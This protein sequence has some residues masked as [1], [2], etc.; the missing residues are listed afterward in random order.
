MLTWFVTTLQKNAELAVFIALAAGYYIGPKKIAGFGLGNGTATLLAGVVVGQLRI[1]ISPPLKA[2]AFVLFLFA[3]GYKVGPQFFAGLKREGLRQVM[4]GLFYAVLGL[5]ASAGFAHAVHFNV[6]QAAGL[7]AGSL[8]QPTTMGTSN[9]AID[10]L[11]LSPAK[12]RVFEEQLAVGFAVSYVVGTIVAL[13]VCSR[14][15]PFL[16]RFDLAEECRKLAAQ[17]GLKPD[18]QPGIFGAYNA[19]AIR[20]VRV[21]ETGLAGHRVGDIESD[22]E[23]RGQRVFVAAIHR[24]EKI[25]PATPSDVVSTGDVIA[26][27]GPIDVIVAEAAGTE[28]NDPRLLDMLTIEELDVVVTNRTLDGLTVD[29]L[30]HGRARGVVLKKITRA[31]I[32][33]PVLPLTEIH[34]GD[35]LQLAGFL[36]AVEAAAKTAGYAV[37]PSPGADVVF[38]SIAIVIGSL[39]GVITVFAGG[40]PIALGAGVGALLAGLVAGYLRSRFPTFGNVSPGA[41]WV[42]ESF[43]LT[44]FVAIIGIDAGPGFVPGVKTAGLELFLGGLL[45]PL[46]CLVISAYFGTYVL[47]IRNVELCGALAGADTSVAALNALKDVAKSD[48]VTLGYTTPYAI[49]S[50]VLTV[51][52]AV[53]VAIF[54][55]QT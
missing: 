34:V 26:L 42:F 48:L 23:R 13:I 7:L 36:R 27:A 25:E 30:F 17:M 12:D 15:I 46:I 52:G 49:G 11:G 51:W 40:I 55:S 37:R 54:A 28:V 20:A 33:I 10:R 22:F 16:L 31:S 1:P 53:I 44:V 39:V 50:I 18:R 47:K 43:S 45:I 9:D 3:M 14:L 24:G 38:M 4:L 21:T 32:G 6:A 19:N 41:L 8:T 35:T 5:L 2:F 29:G